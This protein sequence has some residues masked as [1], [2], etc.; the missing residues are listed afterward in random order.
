MNGPRF[1]CDFEAS[2]VLA[3]FYDKNKKENPARYS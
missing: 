1:Y 3:T 2:V